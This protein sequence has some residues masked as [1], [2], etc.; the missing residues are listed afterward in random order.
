MKK[1]II[2][3]LKVIILMDAIAKIFVPAYSPLI[4]P[5]EIAKVWLPGI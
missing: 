1:V 4:R 2:G 3:R 5:K